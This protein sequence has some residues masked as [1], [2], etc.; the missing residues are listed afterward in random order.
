VRVKV[1]LPQVRAEPVSVPQVVQWPA[2]RRP[3]VVIAPEDDTATPQDLEVV[4]NQTWP[5][6]PFMARWP[7]NLAEAALVVQPVIGAR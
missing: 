7:L 4:T 1:H 6:R 2:A 3:L 5:W